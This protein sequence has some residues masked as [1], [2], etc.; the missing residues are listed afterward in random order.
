MH[1]A[2][3]KNVKKLLRFF[4]YAVCG[5]LTALP[6]SDGRLWLFAWIFPVPVLFCEYKRK[7]EE[8]RYLFRAWKRGLNFFFFY[9]FVAFMWLRKLYP[10]DY[11]GFTNGESMLIIVLGMVGMPLLQ[12]TVSSFVFV[13]SAYL[14]K[15]G[16]LNKHPVF[17]FV[18][19]SFLWVVSEW[20]QTLTFAGVPWGR[21]A[22]GQTEKLAVIQTASLFGSYFVAFVVIATSS[23]LTLAAVRASEMKI[24]QS[25]LLFL[26]AVL[27]F[28]ANYIYGT[29][30]IA[31][32]DYSENREIAVAALQGNMLYEDV[33]SDKQEYTE[34]VYRS[35]SYGA[36]QDG[37]E[38]IVMPETAI[39]YD[40]A[41]DS[42]VFDYFT[43]LYEHTG[44][45]IIGTAFRCEGEKLYNITFTVT[46]NGISGEYY[47][48]RHLVPF[49]EYLPCEKIINTL[50]PPLARLS[51]ID[52]PLTAGNEPTVFEF[53]GMK[54]S[55][56]VCFDSVFEKLALDEVRGGSQ[57]LCVSTNDSWFSG[58]PALSQHNKQTVLR[59][60]ECERYAV[61]AAN[62]GIS[63]IVSP[64]GEILSSLGDGKR[65]YIT[66]TVHLLTTRTLYSY[67]GN[68]I[69]A[70]GALY[71]F[72]TIIMG[73]K[74][75]NR[76]KKRTGRKDS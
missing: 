51:E 53:S 34:D 59:C 13:Y 50:C 48:K 55:S 35:L 4:L 65:G 2:A 45:D 76:D 44:T 18:G 17:S 58:S 12:G 68:S 20:M 64:T 57:L 16:F 46:E 66:D 5:I 22:I 10:M 41:A 27:T 7:T 26:C 1:T 11:M 40:M 71:I 70:I 14:R 69:V 72:V 32:S 39:P 15:K 28:S 36:A 61:R 3:R 56:L 30:K 19:V 60:V 74:Y 62:T 21:I 49:G 8:K 73:R 38:L 25:I 67:I 24:K 37:A 54:V 23:L 6:L 75:G 43:S 31:V 63:S 33:R 29:V 9:G 42:A 47:A 52:E